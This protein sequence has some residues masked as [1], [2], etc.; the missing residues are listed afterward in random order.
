MHKG[1]QL[2]PAWVY[3]D[4]GQVHSGQTAWDR[5]GWRWEFKATGL[6]FCSVAGRRRDWECRLA[7]GSLDS[8][9]EEAIPCSLQRTFPC[10]FQPSLNLSGIM[11]A[12]LPHSWRR[13]R[14]YGYNNVFWGC[15]LVC[16]PIIP[17]EATTLL[18]GLHSQVVAN[19]RCLVDRHKL[20]S[21]E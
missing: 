21:F 14:R 9:P 8:Q 13:G 2:E 12:L 10:P 20:V 4:R 16:L 3:K 11:R 19:R 1:T 15:G 7:V 5:N 6:R 17:Q 18:S